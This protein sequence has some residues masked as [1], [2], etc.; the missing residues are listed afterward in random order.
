MQ[1]KN[2]NILIN[3]ILLFLPI[4]IENLDCFL[5]DDESYSLEKIKKI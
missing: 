2:N 1:L 3:R 4:L 5:N